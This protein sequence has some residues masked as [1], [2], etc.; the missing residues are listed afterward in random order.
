MSFEKKI[1]PFYRLY[2]SLF[3]YRTTVDQINNEITALDTRIK[4]IKKQIELPTTEQDVKNQMT[5]FLQV[6]ER[7]VSM[8]QRGMKE[9][10]AL[11]IQLSEFFCEDP[12]SFKL[13]ECFKIFH[14]FCEKF[15]QA[16][17]ENERRRLQEEQATIRRKQ[18]EEQLAKR[19]R[20]SKF[21]C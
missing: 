11:R 5:E 13:E 9:V 4:N 8:L 16:V 14:N 17:N 12:G 21:C 19:A 10:E 3:H 6:A 2:H 7:E 18:R 15:K 1:F 20:Q